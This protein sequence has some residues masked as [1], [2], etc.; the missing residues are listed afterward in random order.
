MRYYVRQD[1]RN[2]SEFV[3]WVY[4]PRAFGNDLNLA[5]T[6]PEDRI[7]QLREGFTAVAVDSADTAAVEVKHRRV[8]YADMPITSPKDSDS[9]FK[10]L[11]IF[12][13]KPSA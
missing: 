4:G 12:E 7:D 13:E 10:T 11:Q 6:I 2:P 3:H 5:I 9:H 8:A 1:E